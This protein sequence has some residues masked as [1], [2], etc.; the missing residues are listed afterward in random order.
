MFLILLIVALVAAGA[1]YLLAKDVDESTKTLSVELLI[2]GGAIAL[3]VILTEIL[4]LLWE[5]LAKTTR[6]GKGF[7][8]KRNP[9]LTLLATIYLYTTL[10][11]AY[12][13]AYVIQLLFN[14]TLGLCLPSKYRRVVNGLIFRFQ[15][16]PVWLNPFWKV[17][18]VGKKPKLPPGS[19]VMSNHLTFADPF[20]TS[21]VLWPFETKYIATGWVKKIP[22]AGGLFIRSGDLS[23]K[24]VKDEDGKKHVDKVAIAKTLE[25]ANTY[26]E[27]GENIFVYPE[28]TRSK[29]GELKEFKGNAMFKLAIEKQ[30]HIIP[31]AIWGTQTLWLHGKLTPQPG[32]AEAIIGEPIPVN[33]E[34]D[35]NELKE[36]V[37]LE[38]LR[39]RESLPLY[40]ATKED[41]NVPLED[42][43]G[44]ES[45]HSNPN[46][47]TDEATKNID[48]INAT[49]V[50]SSNP[51]FDNV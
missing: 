40:Q 42:H 7:P 4:G 47:S 26:L 19:I 51:M 29:T 11:V 8:D 38:I 41:T 16:F 12:P 24:F 45:D 36:T 17:K 23:I 25:D 1:T 5:K 34:D 30:A 49:V 20:I 6:K 39:L 13:L 10:T 50:T 21:S 27:G 18:L 44:G 31:M 48:G 33:A 14:Y 28:G 2:S 35:L 46:S 43:L 32:Y 37:R 15:L 3:F 9:I 22:V